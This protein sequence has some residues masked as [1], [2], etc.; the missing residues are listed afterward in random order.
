MSN[1]QTETAQAFADAYIEAMATNGIEELNDRLL[2]AF[3][4]SKPGVDARVGTG[5]EVLDAFDLG[6]GAEIDAHALGQAME[7]VVTS[8]HGENGSYY[9]PE[10]I[11]EFMVRR[12]VHPAVLEEVAG[13]DAPS[14]DALYAWIDAIP[15]RTAAACLPRLDSVSVCDPACGSGHY[16]I[17]ALDELVEIRVRFHERAGDPVPRWRLAR[18]TAQQNLYGVDIA[19]E[20][21][22]MAKLRL[23]L[24]VLE[25][26]PTDLARQYA[27]QKPEVTAGV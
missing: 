17:G 19:E 10:Q 2:R 4:A 14:A 12:T 8:L 24:S 22:E 18:Q 13:V 11:V 23:R 25:L 27:P 7:T 1:N 5:I 15:P 6:F 20:A 16:L 26:L 9:T 21:V 3:A